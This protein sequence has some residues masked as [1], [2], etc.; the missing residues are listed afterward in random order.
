MKK[1]LWMKSLLVPFHFDASIGEASLKLKS[2]GDRAA[3][4]VQIVQLVQLETIS[5]RQKKDRSDS[6]AI[7]PAHNSSR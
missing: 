4:T 2:Q 3:E 1:K 5:L 6:S 7:H